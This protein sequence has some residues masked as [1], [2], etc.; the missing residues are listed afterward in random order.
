MVGPPVPGQAT[1]S[2]LLQIGVGLAQPT[3]L[4]HLLVESHVCAP[5]LPAASHFL[6][7]GLHA[8]HAPSRHAG[9]GPL[10]VCTVATDT[11]SGPHVSAIS[12]SQTASPGFL[13]EHSATML[14]HAPGFAPGRESQRLPLSQS[15]LV[16]QVPLMHTTLCILMFAEHPYDA[17]GSQQVPGWPTVGL[18]LAQPVVAGAAVPPVAVALPPRPDA[19]PVA[20]LVPPV[21]GLAPTDVVLA[22]GGLPPTDVCSALLAPPLWGCAPPRPEESTFEVPPLVAAPPCAFTVELDVPLVVDVPPLAGVPLVPATPP[23][24]PVPPVDD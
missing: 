9:V 1:H 5:L 24:G 8:T 7:P 18:V 23:V 13:P 20:G 22:V 16:V 3:G 19:P 14:L 2:P 17:P 12:P 11:K 15:P 10:Q 4:P 21:D 6:S